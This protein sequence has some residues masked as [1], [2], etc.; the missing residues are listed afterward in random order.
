MSLI[1]NAWSL[2]LSATSACCVNIDSEDQW[3]EGLV[4]WSDLVDYGHS[5]VEP[6]QTKCMVR[7]GGEKGAAVEAGSDLWHSNC[8]VKC[9]M[10]ME[11]AIEK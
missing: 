11:D 8:T 1:V 9:T 5:V 10:D 3:W 4:F 6:G 2:C 7:G